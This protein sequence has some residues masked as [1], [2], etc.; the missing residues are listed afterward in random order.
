[1]LAFLS[2]FVALGVLAAMTSDARV[3]ESAFASQDLGLDP[4]P[5]REEWRDAPR[6]LVTQE[7]SG[8]PIDGPPTEIRSRW[9]KAH[10]Y[11]LYIC[12]YDEL[13]VK[14]EPTTD[15]ETPKLWNWDVAEAFIGS[16]FDRIVRYKEFQVS[17]L[18]EW[19]DLDIDRADPTRQQGM[20]WDSGF[21]VAARIDARAKVW[22]GVMRIPFQA[23]DTRSPE[24]GRELRLGLYRISGREPARTYHAW[25]P[26]YQKTF[27]VPDAFGTLRLR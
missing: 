5:A 1:M 21:S 27:H 15:A 23:I 7:M 9:T 4:D 20:Q 14:T 24:A 8:R 11:L 16:D 19:I 18:G 10:L 6:V 22:Y 3:L 13:N 2:S 26:T 17:P 12:P 25:Q